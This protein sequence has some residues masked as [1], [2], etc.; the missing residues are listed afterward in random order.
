MKKLIS[1][2]LI[3]MFLHSLVIGNC[4]VSALDKMI[5]DPAK[6]ET[7]AIADEY[8]LAP[9]DTLEIKITNQKNMDTKQ[10]IAPDGSISLPILGRVTASGQ[11]LAEFSSYLTKE[12]SKYVQNPQI[13]IYLTPRPI[14]IIQHNLD[15][16]T[17]EVKEA[18]TIEEAYAY[19]GKDYKGEIHYG[20]VI[21]VYTSTAPDWWADNWYRMITGAAVL[22]GIYATL[23]K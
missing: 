20:D 11:T 21:H 1:L 15:K 19:A 5:R 14:Y 16:N 2:F 18:K 23:H 17:W 4:P 13:I 9:N 6:R 7:L 8:R 3:T 10:I 12:F 22:V